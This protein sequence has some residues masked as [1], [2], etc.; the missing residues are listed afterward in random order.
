MLEHPVHPLDTPLVFS[1]HHYH[2][3]I[4]IKKGR[5]LKVQQQET[6]SKD[7][8]ND[9]EMG[10]KENRGNVLIELQCLTVKF[11]GFCFQ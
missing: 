4:T 3:S 7:S 5:V 1:I 9:F 10:G 8:D 2:T 6:G 11:C